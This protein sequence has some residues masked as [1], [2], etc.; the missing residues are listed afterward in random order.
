MRLREMTM[1]EFDIVTRRLDEQAERMQRLGDALDKLVTIWHE[2]N[3]R[4]E[5][6]GL[7][8]AGEIETIRARLD[9]IERVLADADEEW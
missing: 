8:I 5:A 4:D 9:A 1:S 6:I 7:R 2:W 3:D